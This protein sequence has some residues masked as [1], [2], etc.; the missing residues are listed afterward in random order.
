MFVLTSW[1]ILSAVYPSC[2]HPVMFVWHS[3]L[4]RVTSD[5]ISTRL[6]YDGHTDLPDRLEKATRHRETFAKSPCSHRV[7]LYDIKNCVAMTSRYQP[8]QPNC[9]SSKVTYNIT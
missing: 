5:I 4:H 6:L 2:G 7:T 1:S 8:K 9:N 3:F